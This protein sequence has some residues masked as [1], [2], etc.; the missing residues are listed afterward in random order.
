MSVN[1]LKI[2]GIQAKV[3]SL[4]ETYSDLPS[5]LRPHVAKDIA[6]ALGRL[7]GPESY[8]VKGVAKTDGVYL[9]ET[10]TS[11]IPATPVARLFAACSQLDQLITKLK[12]T[13]GAYQVEDIDACITVKESLVT[14]LRDQYAGKV[15][16][17]VDVAANA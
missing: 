6:V 7:A 14:S 5:D 9:G 17:P 1:I 10:Q 8:K 13:K 16:G 11:K 12:S 15:N 4:L 2:M 3:E